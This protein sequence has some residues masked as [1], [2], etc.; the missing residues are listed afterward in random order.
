MTEHQAATMTRATMTLADRHHF[1]IR[2]LHSL[3]GIVPVGVFVCIHLATNASILVPGEPGA[4]FQRSVERIHALGPLLVPVE[5]IGIFIPIAFHALLGVKIWLSSSPNARAYRYGSNVRYTIQRMT[6][7]I[8]FAFILYHL[9]H[10]HW[11]GSPL[12]GGAFALHDEA[13]A[14][15]G[16]RTTAAALQASR[17]IPVV[18]ALGI[19]AT[20]FHLANGVWTSLITWGITIRPQTQRAAGYVCAV[21]GVLLGVAGLGALR[22]FA[23]FDLG[24]STSAQGG[25]HVTTS[26]QAP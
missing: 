11:L 12:G 5:I 13:G 7:M 1:L 25:A 21:F 8:V 6:G 24:D 2:R 26:P 10:M 9:W 15:A 19:V 16:A 4:E 23:T 3:T 14:A 22:G 17:W 18:Y 20:V